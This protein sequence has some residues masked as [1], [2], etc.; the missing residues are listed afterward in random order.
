MLTLLPE[1]YMVVKCLKI[2][3]NLVNSIDYIVQKLS[4]YLSLGLFL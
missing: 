4:N 1:L 2:A 3:P